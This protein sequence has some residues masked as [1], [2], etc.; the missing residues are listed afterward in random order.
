MDTLVTARDGAVLTLS[1]SAVHI[2]VNVLADGDVAPRCP[3]DGVGGLVASVGTFLLFAFVAWAEARGWPGEGVTRSRVRRLLPYVRDAVGLV[4]GV[5]FQI[6]TKPQGF[7]AGVPV[8]GCDMRSS[9]YAMALWILGEML[10]F[11]AAL[12]LGRVWEFGTKL[13][14]T[15]WILAGAVALQML[16]GVAAGVLSEVY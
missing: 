6:T 13:W 9:G 14:P 5:W 3:Y 11:G 15:L 16:V 8:E 2:G 10:T 4:P 12:R 1:F 7:Y